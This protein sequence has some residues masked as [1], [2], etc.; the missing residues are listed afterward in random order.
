M[1]GD[2][3]GRPHAGRPQK[4]P[5]MFFDDLFVFD[6]VS[7]TFFS[8]SEE[9]AL[10]LKAVWDGRGHDEIEEMM[11]ARFQIERGSGIRDIE[12]FLLKLG[13]LDLLPAVGAR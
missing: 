8:V 2:K 9:A 6:R 4:S 10:I 3:H 12:Q 5:F 13:E 11:I 7:G 1:R